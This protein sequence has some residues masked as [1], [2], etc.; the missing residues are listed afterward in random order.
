MATE[1]VVLGNQP[2][3]TPTFVAPANIVDGPNGGVRVDPSIKVEAPKVEEKKPTYE[4]LEKSYNELRS[5]MSKEG[6]PKV[7]AAKVE[8]P[9]APA[10]PVVAP[11]NAEAVK[12]VADAGLNMEALETEYAEK[13]ALSEESLKALEAKGLTRA[14][15]NAYIDGQKA[16]NEVLRSEFAKL[17]GGEDR[18]ASV[19]EWAGA[20]MTAE[21][22]DL[23]NTAIDTGNDT[24][25]KMLFRG[26]AAA[27]DAIN[28]RD[29]QL[30]TGDSPR[31]S[32][33]LAYASDAQMVADMAKPEY[34][35]DPAFRAHVR[36]RLAAGQRGTR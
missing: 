34:N 33:V 21:E 4:D 30:I 36:A 18:L 15:V 29:P 19:F 7:E 25:A 17:A 12:A 2:E 20:N 35:S 11:S 6:A 22:L 10:T 24:Q 5:K 16:R 32:N 23:Y 1:T 27:H 3:A 14:Q 13:G 31:G 9:A 8:T 28:G 26:M